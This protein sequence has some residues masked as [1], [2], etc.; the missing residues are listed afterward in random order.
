MRTARRCISARST[1]RAR[2]RAKSPPA[3][4][5]SSASWWNRTSRR[6][7]RISCRGSRSYTARASPTPASAGRTA[8]RCSRTS[9]KP[10]A[11]ARSC[12]PKN[13]SDNPGQTT[14]SDRAKADPGSSRGLS[15]VF[16]GIAALILAFKLWLSAVFPFTGDE[17]YFV[18]WGV[19]PD[20]GY[21]DHPPMIGWLL[22]LLLQLSRAEWV[23]RLP[24]TLLPFALAA[25]IFFVLR[26]LD[27]MKAAL[28]ALA[29]MLLPAN[30]W[31]VFITTD[32]PL[33]FF[34]FASAFAFWLGIVRRSPGWQGPPGGVLLVPRASAEFSALVV[35][36][37]QDHRLA[38]PRA[39]PGCVSQV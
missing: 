27:E 15:P 37:S 35:L 5:A 26:R 16:W 20:Y 18:D 39:R 11:S 6:D 1:S 28:A 24:V 4:I 32:T 36:V 29:F 31:S 38:S 7:A 17:A 34:S 3:K 22:A 33:I 14:F 19:F 25:G 9:P 13:P 30:V 21:Y 2:S 10:C 12:K 23:L 8:C